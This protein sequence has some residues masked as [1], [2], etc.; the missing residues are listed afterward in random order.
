[1]AKYWFDSLGLKISYEKSVAISI[2]NGQ[3]QPNSNIEIDEH[4]FIRGLGEEESIKY[5]GINFNSQIT[6]DSHKVIKQL[7]ESMDSLISS[8]VL[9][10]NQKILIINEYIWSKI[11]Y[12]LQ[13]APLNKLPMNFLEDID[14]IIRNGVKEIIGLPSDTPTAMMYTSKN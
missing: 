12:P 2:V 4:N 6:F 8:S 10:A 1:M 5:L 14:K 11:V 13:T 7:K 9:Y 3:L